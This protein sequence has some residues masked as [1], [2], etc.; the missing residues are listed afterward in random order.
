MRWNASGSGR[1]A[2]RDRFRLDGDQR[3]AGPE[4]LSRA[5]QD[6]PEIAE[7]LHQ[8]PHDDDIRLRSVG[9]EE[10]AGAEFDALMPGGRR[11]DHLRRDVDPEIG[12]VGEIGRQL[13]Q[14]VTVAATRIDDAPGRRPFRRGTQERQ[15]V[16]EQEI[17]LIF[18]QLVPIARRLGRGGIQKPL[19]HCDGNGH[20]HVS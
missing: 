9:G 4:Q 7:M 19:V 3:A 11:R 16:R 10:I 5:P 13:R 17:D 12:L 18:E 2:L 14:V 8:E 15:L 6:R 20:G 1:I